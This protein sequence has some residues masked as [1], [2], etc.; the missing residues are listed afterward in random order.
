MSELSE[1]LEHI[2]GM[3]AE[4]A[5][6]KSEVDA[7]KGGAGKATTKA[8][9]T[10]RKA[11]AKAPAK[12]KAKATSKAPKAGETTEITPA[13]KA[14]VQRWNQLQMPKGEAR[15]KHGAG[16][17]AALKQLTGTQVARAIVHVEAQAYT[18][19]AGGT[20]QL[21][22]PTGVEATPEMIAKAGAA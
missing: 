21:A 12:A 7:I 2:T 4:V 17:P 13:A 19:K 1:I 22:A 10:P 11:R 18:N 8:K 6:L 3:R 14:W 9:A 5:T 20:W 16:L 15:T